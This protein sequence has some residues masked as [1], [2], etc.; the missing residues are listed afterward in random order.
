MRVPTTLDAARLVP[1]CQTPTSN[2]LACQYIAGLSWVRPGC[3]PENVIRA[4]NMSQA[5]GWGLSA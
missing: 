2:L 4:A 5:A 1:D 3:E